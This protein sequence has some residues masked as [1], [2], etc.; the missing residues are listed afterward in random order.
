MFTRKVQYNSS[1]WGFST[2]CWKV[3][4]FCSFSLLSIPEHYLKYKIALWGWS[5]QWGNLY[6]SFLALRIYP[7]MKQQAIRTLFIIVLILVFGSRC[8][9]M[10][11]LPNRNPRA[12][13]WPMKKL[14]P[15]CLPPPPPVHWPD[16]CLCCPPYWCTIIW[17]LCDKRFGLSWT[18]PEI[19]ALRRLLQVSKSREER[20]ICPTVAHLPRWLGVLCASILMRKCLYS[21]TEKGYRS[22][23]VTVRYHAA[24]EERRLVQLSPSSERP[25]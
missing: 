2:G 23:I 18:F 19:E 15:S 22:V 25:R 8:F 9:I 3:L 11:I 1:Y 16:P 21:V 6:L 14:S 4:F 13:Y 20:K 24:W 10:K 7:N 17:N 12:T 5:E